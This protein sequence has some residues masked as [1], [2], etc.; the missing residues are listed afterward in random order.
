[1]T[2]MLL[3]AFIGLLITLCYATGFEFGSTVENLADVPEKYRGLYSKGDDGKFA[4][5]TDLGK[6]LDT[7]GLTGALDKERKKARELEKAVNGWKSLELGDSPE[8]A[9][10]KIKATIAE[11]EDGEGG[12]DE[13]GKK[14]G[15]TKQIM[16]KLKADAEAQ[17]EANKTEYETRLDG[18]KTTLKKQMIDAEAR[19]AIA[20]L[21]GAADLLLPHV[22]E[23]C[24]LLE[25]DGSFVVR[26]V[27]EEGD[28]RSNG[29]G[30]WMTIKELIAEM[31]S[32]ELY[33]R[34]FESTGTKGSGTPPAARNSGGG[35]SDTKLTP[36][37][38]I[39]RGLDQQQAR[40]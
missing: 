8:E 13:D 25:E 6:K 3:L 19:A 1:M 37:Q 28:P 32:G 34:A 20:E 9:L 4:I 21:K 40:R 14:A 30:G 12:D 16:L 11:L 24:Q 5:D 10:E 7:S 17:I 22:R 38:K 15:K 29:K 33:G 36:I 26:V 35:G 18:M 2:I 31:K 27:D 23:K 39:Q